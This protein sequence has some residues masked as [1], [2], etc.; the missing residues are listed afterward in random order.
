MPLNNTI[1]SLISFSAFFILIVFLG[2]SCQTSGTDE[3][4]ALV[5]R[6][7]GRKIL[8]PEKSL[9]NFTGLSII[10]NKDLES[11]T[12]YTVL[13]YISPKYFS[14][15]YVN[16]PG[17]HSFIKSLENFEDKF[18]II[19]IVES[20]SDAEELDVLLKNEKSHKIS[21][22]LDDK[23]TF[24]TKNSIE[25]NID[26]HCFLLDQNKDVLAVGNPSSKS[27]IKDYYKKLIT[28][29][30]HMDFQNDFPLTEVSLPQ[31]IDLQNVVY[32]E[33][34]EFSFD[35]TNVGS[36]T[37]LISDYIISCGCVTII[38]APKMLS[39]SETGNV[40]VNFYAE[41]TGDIYRTIDIHANIKEEKKTI[42]IYATVAE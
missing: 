40:V 9:D 10:E 13:F 6:W 15:C 17:W 32:E 14:R 22:I 26:F 18:N 23:F 8:I 37:L 2:S 42:E 24:V 21:Y 12:T 28:E 25:D 29:S 7:I 5:A 3:N 11:G 41:S 31:K 35:I 27:K 34:V 19:F 1:R 20:A 36:N 33:T 39:P 16:L 38:E 30:D 4:K